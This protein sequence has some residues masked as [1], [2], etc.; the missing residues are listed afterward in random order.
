MTTA[1]AQPSAAWP[2]NTHI[3][4]PPNFSAFHSV[5]D[6]LD[7]AAAE[8]LRAIG[9]SNYY[10]HSVYRALAEQAGQRG[11]T[12]LFGLE[13]VARDA[14]LAHNGVK[15][16]DPGNPGKVYLCGKA[17]ARVADPGPDA[18]ALMDRIRTG[19]AERIARMTA[20]VNAVFATAGYPAGLT[21]DAIRAAVSTRYNA[22]LETVYLQE[23]H[24]AQAFQ[25]WLWG[26]VPDTERPV[27]LE[28]ILGAPLGAPDDPVAVQDALR[29]HLMKAGRPA[30]VEE[31][32]VSV[33][34]AKRLVLGLGGI[35]CYPVLLDGAAPLCPFE[36][37][38]EGLIHR[39]HAWGIHAVEFIPV[40]N[41]PDLL[42]EYVAGLRGA[43]FV[44][45]AGTEHNTLDRIPLEPRCRDGA[46]LPDAAR[47]AFEEGACVLAAHQNR[48]AQG[49]AGF[50]DE[51]GAPN[52]DYPDAEAR[53]AAFRAE[54]VPLLNGA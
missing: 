31:R 47:R 42:A 38:W 22:P 2:V 1:S 15:V 52:P 49:H 33:E 9:A 32:F 45:T 46:P 39:L 25:E 21:A 24:V 53:I 14:T 17:T 26:A 12:P 4:L 27:A 11:I 54:G 6:A 5:E 3:H 35:P 44:V 51:N 20:G 43:G 50:V 19:D 28:R 36:T 40:R 23:R 48:V 37:P 29:S 30:F 10:D 34:D 18:V 41:R 7:M 13:I 8:G 16:N